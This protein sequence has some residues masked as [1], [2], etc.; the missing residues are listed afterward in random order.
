[1]EVKYIDINGVRMQFVELEDK[2]LALDNADL[3]VTHLDEHLR[4][5]ILK[6]IK[7]YGFN[8][9]SHDEELRDWQEA[10]MLIGKLR[11]QSDGLGNNTNKYEWI[12]IDEKLTKIFEK[13]KL[14]KLPPPYSVMQQ[15]VHRDAMGG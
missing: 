14:P 9:R 2:D 4:D 11:K 10:Y 8:I 15:Y 7:V 3:P 12:R 5:V 13:Q 1:M 6:D